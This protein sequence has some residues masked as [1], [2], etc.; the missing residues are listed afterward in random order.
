MEGVRRR[1]LRW[2]PLVKKV[3]SLP[4]SLLKRIFKVKTRQKATGLVKITLNFAYNIN[5]GALI[6]ATAKV[7]Q[8]RVETTTMVKHQKELP[9]FTN[10]LQRKTIIYFSQTDTANPVLVPFIYYLHSFTRSLLLQGK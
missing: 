3:N 4:R 10:N 9:E 5:R 7:K 1:K 6:K 2:K 8:R